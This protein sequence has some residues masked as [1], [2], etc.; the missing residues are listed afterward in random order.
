MAGNV[1]ILFKSFIG[2][3]INKKLLNYQ[4]LTE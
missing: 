1:K 4:Q 2:R 3:N